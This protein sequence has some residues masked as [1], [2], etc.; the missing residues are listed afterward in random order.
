[1]RALVVCYALAFALPWTVWST[2]IAQQQG[3]LGWH[4]P[5]PLAFWLGLP[6]AYLVAAAVSGGRPALRDLA[7]R[8]LRWRV[9]WRV[10]GLALVLAIGLPGIVPLVLILAGAWRA[11]DGLVPLVQLPSSLFV[12]TLLFWLTEEATW[13]GFVLPRIELWLSPGNAGLLVGILWALWH[14]PLFAITGS[15]QAGLPFV[16]FALL[17]VSTALIMSWLYHRGAQSV[18][19][20]ALYHG[21]VDMVFAAT[22]V[23]SASR[24]SFWAVVALHVVIAAGLWWG[25]LRTIKKTG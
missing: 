4:L 18:L 2:T 16:G 7:S 21:V 24:G 17:T 25:P 6:T 13:R 15:F 3:R 8:L 5:Q 12:E 1:M 19:P 22:G 10:Y 23:L 20:C 14:L 9:G 11:P